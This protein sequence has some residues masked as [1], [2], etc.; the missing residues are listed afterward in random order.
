MYGSSHAAILGGDKT[1]SGG[2]SLAKSLRIPPWGHIIVTGAVRHA[3][4]GKREEGRYRHRGVIRCQKYLSPYTGKR[5]HQDQLSCI[6]R[7]KYCSGS[8]FD[9]K[10]WKSSTSR[11]WDTS[12]LS[13]K[14]G[15][16][17]PLVS[18]HASGIAQNR[19]RSRRERIWQVQQ[20]NFALWPPA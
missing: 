2:N 18:Q 20:A 17:N 14:G 13:R 7:H 9:S 8:G 12:R 10:T 19:I 5:E 4:K 16:C 3:Q 6:Y 15:V 1:P 11:S